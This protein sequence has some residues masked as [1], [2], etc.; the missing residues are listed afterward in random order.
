MTLGG[1]HMP[2]NRPGG[3]SM[4]S[5]ARER[6]RAPVSWTISDDPWRL[7]R[8]ATT[9]QQRLRFTDLRTITSVRFAVVHCLVDYQRRSL[10]FGA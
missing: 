7:E 9:E 1:R 6:R 2:V 5:F 3:A 4:C 8:D 10:A